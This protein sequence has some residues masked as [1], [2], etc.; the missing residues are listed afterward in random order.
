MPVILPP[1]PRGV[2]IHGLDKKNSPPASLYG[3][4]AEELSWNGTGGWLT[5]REGGTMDQKLKTILHDGSEEFSPLVAVIMLSLRK[6]M[7]ED[8]ISAF[9]AVEIAR[10][11]NHK[12]FGSTAGVLEK[13]NLIKESGEMHS[14]IRS[15]IKNAAVGNGAELAIRSPVAR[16]PKEAS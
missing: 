13:L 7:D 10:D 16:L 9:E 1:K 4:R 3:V 6:L 2:Q 5:N 15:I 8:P 14:S 11:P 12:P